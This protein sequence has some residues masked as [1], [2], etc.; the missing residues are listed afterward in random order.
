MLVKLLLLVALAIVIYRLIE[1]QVTTVI[2]WHSESAGTQLIRVIEGGM[3]P[4][5]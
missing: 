1:R 3:Q 5:G 2:V 4:L